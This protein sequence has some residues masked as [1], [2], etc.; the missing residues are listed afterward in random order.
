LHLYRNRSNFALQSKTKTGMQDTSTS[1]QVEKIRHLF[2]FDKR[3]LFV[4]LCLA[5]VLI[6]DLF[7]NMV[8]TENMYYEAWG[9]QL[10]LDRIEK[11]LEANKKWAWIAYILMPILM[12]IRMT[13]TT[14]CLLTATVLQDVKIGFKRIFQIV[15]VAEVVYLI[16]AIISLIYFLCIAK[17]YTIADVQNFDFY[18]LRA[19]IGRENIAPWLTYAFASLNLFELM[20]WAVLA[21][22]FAL[23]LRQG[24]NKMLGLVISGYGTGLLLWIVSITFLL[25]S[26][27]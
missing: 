8:V 23:V 26:L 13:F 20:Y 7:Q 1:I 16:P 11:M 5:Y 14:L 21:T 10:A 17:D 24:F 4:V 22:G 2:D 15:L 3:I 27:T 6:I 19:L 12:L 18:S 9:Q 25:V